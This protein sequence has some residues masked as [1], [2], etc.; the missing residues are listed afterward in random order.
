MID[1]DKTSI[2]TTPHNVRRVCHEQRMASDFHRANQEIADLR[3]LLADAESERDGMAQE[4]DTANGFIR[5]LLLEMAAQAPQINIYGFEA[6]LEHLD[7]HLKPDMRLNKNGADFS[8]VLRR[9]H[10]I[11]SRSPKG[12]TE[13]DYHL[14]NPQKTEG[15]GDGS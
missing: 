8:P 10:A 5:G 11:K 12:N 6:V 14:N 1:K 4:L 13:G 3:M 7:K 15:Q 2:G 9:L